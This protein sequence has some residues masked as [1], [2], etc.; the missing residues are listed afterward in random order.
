[1]LIAPPMFNCWIKK[2]NILRICCNS[3]I[4]SQL[5]RAHNIYFL[6]ESHIFVHIIVP[7]FKYFDFMIVNCSCKHKLNL[8]INIK[9]KK[10]LRANNLASYMQKKSNGNHL[11]KLL[12]KKCE[13]QRWKHKFFSTES[14]SSN[15]I[16][17]RFYC[18]LFF[19]VSKWKQSCLLQYL[20]R[21]FWCNIFSF[22]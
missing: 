10:V 6:K 3:K 18:I 13:K 7:I 21:F 17:S 22:T 12:E 5:R 14:Y 19:L 9:I 8:C 11:F 15:V 4:P 20:K 16:L 1:M 2:S